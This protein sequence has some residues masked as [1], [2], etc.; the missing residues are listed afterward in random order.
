MSWLCGRSYKANAKLPHNHQ[1]GRPEQLLGASSLP[2]SGYVALV[3]EG[4][5]D[6][7]LAKQ[8]GYNAVCINGTGNA[9]AVRQNEEADRLS[10]TVEGANVVVAAMDSDQAGSSALER[11]KTQ[12]GHNVRTLPMPK[13]MKDIGDFGALPNGKS[14]FNKAFQEALIA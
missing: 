1:G 8:W 4:T 3:T 13:D 11:L 14:L 7:A 2:T 10:R 9:H 6:Y 5:I 12:L